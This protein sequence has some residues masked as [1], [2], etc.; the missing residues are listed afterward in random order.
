[1]L[2]YLT[3]AA[4]NPDLGIACP[5]L[6]ASVVRL[7]LMDVDK[8]RGACRLTGSFPCLRTNWSLIPKVI[9]KGSM[10]YVGQW[11]NP[12]LDIES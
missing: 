5:C 6:L 2:L 3:D 4:G 1:M 7:W 8:L 9:A 10:D 12:S 11:P